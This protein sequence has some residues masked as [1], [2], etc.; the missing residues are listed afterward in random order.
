IWIDIKLVPG[1][2][3]WT[4][5]IEKAIRS[6]SVMVVLLS[7]AVHDSEWVRNEIGVAKTY[8]KTIIPVFAIRTERPIELT[9]IQGL[10]GE[11]TLIED[12]EKV[13][14]SFIETLSQHNIFPKTM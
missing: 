14:E 6:S 10:R 8:K 9:G 12:F 5:E 2:S 4:R 1:T 13:I 3:V 7:P 11:P